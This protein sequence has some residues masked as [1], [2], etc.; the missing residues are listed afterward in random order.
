MALDIGQA[1]AAADALDALITGTTTEE[2]LVKIK[3]A[4][5]KYTQMA[6]QR[7]MQVLSN[8]GVTTKVAECCSAAREALGV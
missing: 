4:L 8:D 7:H 5:R 6:D 2:D 1:T 3:L